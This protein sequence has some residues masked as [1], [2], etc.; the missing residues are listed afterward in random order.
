MKRFNIDKRVTNS[1]IMIKQ[2]N[3]FEI[4]GIKRC[5]KDTKHKIL[6]FEILI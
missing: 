6:E 4:L 1:C 3:L 5:I 2:E